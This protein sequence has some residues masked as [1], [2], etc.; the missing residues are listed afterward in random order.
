MRVVIFAKC[1]CA[2]ISNEKYVHVCLS[3]DDLS[4]AHTLQT[5]SVSRAEPKL[6]RPPK[7]ST[8]S[9][10]P[11]RPAF[12]RCVCVWVGRGL[13]GGLSGCS[14]CQA[15]EAPAHPHAAHKRGR[16]YMYVR[17]FVAHTS[18]VVAMLSLFGRFT[19]R[20]ISASCQSSIK[21]TSWGM[22]EFSRHPQPQVFGSSDNAIASA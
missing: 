20:I 6:S 3:N 7:Y 13:S 9:T 15:H 21:R 1:K 18:A 17:M 2:L 12:G 22:V 16:A 4:V 8:Y 5:R 11:L 10:A 19:R 14:C